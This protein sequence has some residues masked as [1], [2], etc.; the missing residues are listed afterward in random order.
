VGGALLLARWTEHVMLTSVRVKTMNEYVPSFQS[1]LTWAWCGAPP[2][3]HVAEMRSMKLC[4]CGDARGSTDD[5][6]NDEEEVPVNCLALHG[7]SVATMRIHAKPR[8]FIFVA[9]AQPKPRL[10]CSQKI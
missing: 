6:D 8:A 3:P 7:Q 9:R 2:E 10:I 4:V 1:L 5:E